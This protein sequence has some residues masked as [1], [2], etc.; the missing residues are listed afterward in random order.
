[1]TGARPQ[2]SSNSREL[3][4]PTTASAVR[5]PWRQPLSE[6]GGLKDGL[7]RRQFFIVWFYV[8]QELLWCVSKKKRKKRKRYVCTISGLL[9][10]HSQHL[11]IISIRLFYFLFHDSVYRISKIVVKKKREKKL[12]RYVCTMWAPITFAFTAA[13]YQSILF[14]HLLLLNICDTYVRM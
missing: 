7:W 5:S 10:S 4:C 9:H 11:L 3:G 12:K 1:M 13:S 8:L 14:I 6:H 2:S